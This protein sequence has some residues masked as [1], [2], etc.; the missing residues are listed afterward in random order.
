MLL[1]KEAGCVEHTH[2]NEFG[3]DIAILEIFM[4]SDGFDED[5]SKNVP[6]LMRLN[7]SNNTRVIAI[8]LL[9]GHLNQKL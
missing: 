3:E 1:F 9:R 5:L 2:L 4:V 8:L 6:I 7:F